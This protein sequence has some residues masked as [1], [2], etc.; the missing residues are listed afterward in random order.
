MRAS[1]FH[2]NSSFYT[3]GCNQTAYYYQKQEQHFLPTLPGTKKLYSIAL[4]LLGS[5]FFPYNRLSSHRFH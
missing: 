3:R 4:Y 1:L 5:N 2:P